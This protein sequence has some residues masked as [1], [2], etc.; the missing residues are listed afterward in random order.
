YEIVLFDEWYSILDWNDVVKYLNDI[1]ENVEQKGKLFVPFL[2]KYVFMTS[3][4]LLEEAFNFCRFRSMWHDEIDQHTM[5]LTFHKGFKDDFHNMFWD[6]KY[7]EGGTGKGVEKTV[8][9]TIL[10][11]EEIG[12]SF[13]LFSSLIK[14]KQAEFFEP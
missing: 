13:S 1:P 9:S 3:Y 12:D 11:L 7:D 8:L 4:K 5:E 6:I 2:A 10:I 14:N